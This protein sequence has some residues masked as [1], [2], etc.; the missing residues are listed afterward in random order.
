MRRIAILGCSFSEWYNDQYENWSHHIAKNFPDTQVDCYAR[1]ATGQDYADYTIDYLLDQKY[2]CV[3]YQASLGSRISIPL[4]NDLNPDIDTEWNI[5]KIEKQVPE[6]FTQYTINQD[7]IRFTQ[8]SVCVDFLDFD[9]SVQNNFNTNKLVE[10]GKYILSQNNDG[11]PK[12]FQRQYLRH[13]KNLKQ[14]YENLFDNFFWYVHHGSSMQIKDKSL[15]IA[16][17]SNIGHKKCGMD[18]MIDRYGNDPIWFYENI[19]IGKNDPHFTAYG[20]ELLYEEYILKS[21]IGEYLND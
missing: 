12:Y 1:S 21:K 17:V 11:I 7:F 16:E 6:N 18:F 8:N 4:Y 9:G 2:D 20:N 3:I 10:S 13:I 14:K 15:S 19:L 5:C